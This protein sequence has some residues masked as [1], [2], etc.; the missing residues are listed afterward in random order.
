MFFS[1]P[2]SEPSI[3]MRHAV[4]SLQLFGQPGDDVGKKSRRGV[5]HHN[6]AVGCGSCDRKEPGAELHGKTGAA[7]SK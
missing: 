1:E 5:S 6:S 7:A 2:E 3:T 4:G